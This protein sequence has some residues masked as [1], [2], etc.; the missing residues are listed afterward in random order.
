[1]EEATHGNDA[2]FESLESKVG[3]NRELGSVL[4]EMR[5]DS[6]CRSRH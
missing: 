3:I 2:L 4:V 6:L 5:D 1:M